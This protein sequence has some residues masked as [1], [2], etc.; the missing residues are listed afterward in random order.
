MFLLS[1]SVQFSEL[2]VITMKLWA[3]QI[4]DAWENNRDKSCQG[5]SFSFTLEKKK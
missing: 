3:P 5:S 2:S 1:N 4:D